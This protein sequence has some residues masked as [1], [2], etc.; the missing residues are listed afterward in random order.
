VAKPT[1]DDVL[2]ALERLYPHAL[3]EPWDNV[4]LL[5]PPGR[6]G[7]ARC[8]R[9]LCTIDLTEAVAD[10]ACSA[11]ADLILAYHPPIFAPLR[12]FDGARSIDRALLRAIRA[13]VGVFSPHTAVDAA[14][15]GVNDW[16][17]DALGPGR[18][19]PIVAA[20]AAPGEPMTPDVAGQGRLVE[21]DAPSALDALVARIKVHL[22]LDRV[23][24]ADSDRHRAGTP[25]RTVALCAGAGGKL[26]ESVPEVDLLWTGEMRHHDVVARV[27]AGTSVVLCEHSNTERGYLVR[28]AARLAGAVPDLDV[29]VS[30]R[31]REPLEIR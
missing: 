5:V 16:L 6:G 18:R 23:R 31:D 25:V 27:A 13:G 4:G 2:E 1:L 7:A 15:A 21:L 9:V 14:P 30:S 20:R 19:R 8:R 3:A 24:V 10:E 29:I 12:R 17:A 11:G 22:D 26:F 28:L